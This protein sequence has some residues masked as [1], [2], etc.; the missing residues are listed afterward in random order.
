MSES[1]GLGVCEYLV[2]RPSEE[3]ESECLEK[4]WWVSRRSFAISAGSWANNI[5]SS[6]HFVGGLYHSPVLG[7][8]RVGISFAI[9]GRWISVAGD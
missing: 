4:H 8:A 7:P 2:G 3:P 9:V 1:H 5:P 6:R